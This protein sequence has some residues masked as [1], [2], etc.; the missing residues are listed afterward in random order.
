VK[1]TTVTL[2]DEHERALQELSQPG[3]LQDT[4]RAW[5]AER[6]IELTDS[7]AEAALV[8]VLM[9]AGVEHLRGPALDIGYN[10]LAT[11]YAEEGVAE[12][13]DLLTS[14]SLA[15]AGQAEA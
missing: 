13:I 5:A 14:D 1:R 10:E 9:D 11:I 15:P 8:R 4:A 2:T 3:P 6:G 12:E 7:P